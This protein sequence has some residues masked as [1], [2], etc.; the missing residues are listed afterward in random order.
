MIMEYLKTSEGQE[1][2]KEAIMNTI[3]PSQIT[4]E[5]FMKLFGREG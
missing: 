5:L 3:V 1:L 4:K 2:L